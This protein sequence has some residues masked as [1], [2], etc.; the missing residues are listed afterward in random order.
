MLALIPGLQSYSPSYKNIYNNMKLK[1]LSFSVLLF[2]IGLINAQTDF[3][4]G[5]VIRTNENK[6]IG[7]INYRGDLFTVK[8][9]SAKPYDNKAKTEYSSGS[10][11][12]DLAHPLTAGADSTIKVAGLQMDVTNDIVKN[13]DRILSGIKE[14]A[15]AK[16]IFLIT[17]EGSLSGYHCKFNQKELL[18]AMQEIIAYAKEL[19]LGLM[20][21]TCFKID[22]ELCHNQI[23]IYAPE[24]KFLGAHSKV[25][26][27][28]PV[29]FPGT[30][31]M[32]EYEE[33]VLQTFEWNNI[34]FGTLICNDLWATPGYTTIPNPY[35]PL[36]LKQMGAEV[37]F[38]AINSGNNQ[39]YRNF[40]ESSVELWALSLHIPI[41]EVNAAQ[42]KE[43]IN[44]QSG[45]I[46]VNG[47]RS[48]VVP[49]TGEHLFYCQIKL[50]KKGNV[51]K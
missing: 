16:A 30:G 38:H 34:R 46:D 24:G 20:L 31:E 45:L 5:N 43:K 1:V 19:K 28:S 13:K 42:G 29:D 27:C 39:R 35:L 40:H 7:E 18:M 49:D 12:L 32:L 36:K 33:G 50:N 17:P 23:R 2:S 51:L 25:L 14:A 47:V 21:G 37:I 22:E 44:A 15:A 41:M 6:S 4:A 10:K 48:V 26:N 11:N 9:C 8:D 3:P